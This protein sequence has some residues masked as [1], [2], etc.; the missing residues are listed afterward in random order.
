M[1]SESDGHESE[2]LPLHGDRIYKKISKS[3]RSNQRDKDDTLLDLKNPPKLNRH[4][5][6][7]SHCPQM[8]GF[9]YVERP[10]QVGFDIEIFARINESVVKRIA[11][12]DELKRSPQPQILWCAKESLFKALYG[13]QP[14]VLSDLTI[15]SW[16]SLSADTFEFRSHTPTA[17]VGFVLQNHQYIFSVCF[18]DFSVSS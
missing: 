1:K 11:T 9:A 7:I 6:S 3:Q 13:N 12:K 16:N 18:V 8:G 10:F 17:A 2:P 5:V 4:S 15:D 14:K